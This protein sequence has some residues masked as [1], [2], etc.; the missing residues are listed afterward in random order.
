[1]ILGCSTLQM[2]THSIA[3]RGSFNESLYTCAAALFTAPTSACQQAA[4]APSTIRRALLVCSGCCCRCSGA[5]AAL[6][7]L[8]AA[9]LTV[10][11]HCCASLAPHVC[12]RCGANRCL[13]KACGRGS[14]PCDGCK[15]VQIAEGVRHIHGA[16]FPQR[17]AGSNQ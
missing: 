7:L 5:P 9:M 3:A 14:C 1:M 12:K 2:T 6:Q 10:Q 15:P 17:G 11:L 4:K 13:C 16:T 8:L